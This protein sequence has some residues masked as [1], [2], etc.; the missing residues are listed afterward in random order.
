MKSR[1][2]RFL[3]S[4]QKLFVLVESYLRRCIKPLE[5]LLT[6]HKRLVVKDSAV[7]IRNKL[8]IFFQSI[9]VVYLN[10]HLHIS[11]SIVVRLLVVFRA[12]TCTCTCT[13]NA[14]NNNYY[15]YY[16]RPLSQCLGSERYMYV[17][18]FLSNK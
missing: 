5:A 11:Y 14:N 3:F 8:R 9:H 4:Q 18:Y 1:S 12:H 2:S 13:L 17:V 10:L 15:Y 16:V 6:S 7:S